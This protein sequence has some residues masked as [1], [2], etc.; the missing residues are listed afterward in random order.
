MLVIQ[1]RLREETH[2][3]FRQQEECKA[4]DTH[5]TELSR[6]P[7]EIRMRELTQE[8][9]PNSRLIVALPGTPA[10]TC[11]KINRRRAA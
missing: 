6:N 1:P 3:A 10:A 9:K 4:V 8:L 5:F 7:D 2:S 11:G